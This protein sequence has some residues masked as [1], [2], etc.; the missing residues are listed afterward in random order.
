M[1]NRNL[2]FLSHIIITYTMI[3]IILGSISEFA[4]IY[5]FE[6]AINITQ[7]LEFW[8]IIMILVAIISKE[9]KYAI[10]N[11]VILML[12][13]NSTYYIIRLIKSGYTNNGAWN[14][15]NFIC[16]GGALFIAT[17]VF[18]IKDIATR[19]KKYFNICSLISMTILGTI[20]MKFYISFGLRF[21]NLMQYASLGIIVAFILMILLK[22]IYNMC[23]ILKNNK[24]KG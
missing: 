24:A 11:S 22:S 21:N 9:C 20:F 6:F 23:K 15:Y 14:M 10:M 7:S 2:K 17:F 3:G 19:N 18:A 1:K 4:L 16:I 13:M 8:G 12:S 5:N